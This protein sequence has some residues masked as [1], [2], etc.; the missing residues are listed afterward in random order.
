MSST[1]EAL[2][3]INER[4]KLIDQQLSALSKKLDV[5]ADYFKQ[6]MTIEHDY[7]AGRLSL[8]AGVAGESNVTPKRGDPGAT[9]SDPDA[10]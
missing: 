9:S 2:E 8:L 5:W 10:L 4:V 6:R 1:T 7:L 3:L